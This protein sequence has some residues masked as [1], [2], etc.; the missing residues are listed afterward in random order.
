MLN[1][2]PGM[3]PL[4]LAMF[5]VM[6]SSHSMPSVWAYFTMER[7]GWDTAM[8]GYSLAFLGGLSVVVQSSL[9]GAMAKRWGE[10]GMTAMGVSL[11]TAGL[12]LV[13]LSFSAWLLLPA[14]IL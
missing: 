9:V 5:L 2:F 13:T 10:Y 8:V 12:L 14:L 6:L 3:V 7:Y 1:R 11:S 4:L